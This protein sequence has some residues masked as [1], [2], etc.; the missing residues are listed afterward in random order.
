MFNLNSKEENCCSGY[1]RP[2]GDCHGTPYGGFCFIISRVVLSRGGSNPR[3]VAGS[4]K[5]TGL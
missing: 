3:E 4:G 5:P 1:Y 2:L